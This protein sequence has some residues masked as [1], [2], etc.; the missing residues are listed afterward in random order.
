MSQGCHKNTNHEDVNRYED[1]TRQIARKLLGKETKLDN[2]Q[3]R[4]HNKTVLV[5]P[6]TSQ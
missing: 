2:S 3:G 5:V 1:K 4:K 6:M